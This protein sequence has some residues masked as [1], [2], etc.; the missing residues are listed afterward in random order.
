MPGGRPTIYKHRKIYALSME[1]TEFKE[2]SELARI[3]G[4]DLNAIVKQA[5]KEYKANR[6]VSKIT[7]W[8]GNEESSEF[9]AIPTLAWNRRE[10]Y[11]FLKSCSS[12][13]RKN[14]KALLL[15]R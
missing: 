3:A 9:V 13:V 6:N 4:T 8:V 7:A 12:E 15:S 2:L 5:V 1:E 10:F 11:K 14:V